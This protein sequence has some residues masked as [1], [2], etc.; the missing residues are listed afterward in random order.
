MLVLHHLAAN[1]SVVFNFCSLLITILTFLLQ[2]TRAFEIQVWLN[3]LVNSSIS[4]FKALNSWTFSM[5]F[6]INFL[7]KHFPI[8]HLCLL[9]IINFPFTIVT[10]CSTTPKLLTL[11]FPSANLPS[12]LIKSFPDFFFLLLPKLSTFIFWFS[13]VLY[14]KVAKSS[15]LTKKS[16]WFNK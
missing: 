1:A 3:L 14:H 10:V 16:A 7:N 15:F 11:Y 5:N 13:D 6:L 4:S 8:F 2:V 12:I 9:H